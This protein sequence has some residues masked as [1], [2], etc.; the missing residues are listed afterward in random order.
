MQGLEA[1]NV[2]G[3]IIRGTTNENCSSYLLVRHLDR[4]RAGFVYIPMAS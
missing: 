3:M 1:S 4:D 2:Y